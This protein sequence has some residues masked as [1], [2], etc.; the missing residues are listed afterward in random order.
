VIIIRLRK[1]RGESKRRILDVKKLMSP[2]ALE[3]FHGP[4]SMAGLTYKD[5]ES[6]G[7]R[8]VI[9]GRTSKGPHP[10]SETTKRIRPSEK[11]SQLLIK[12]VGIRPADCRAGAKAGWHR[13]GGKKTGGGRGVCVGGGRDLEIT[14]VG[15][16]NPNFL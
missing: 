3:G 12:V 11:H 8:V 7:E 1:R 5:P 6:P 9:A 15:G 4:S 14:N 16:V 10:Y 13:G 2:E